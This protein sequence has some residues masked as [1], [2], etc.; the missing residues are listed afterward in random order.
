MSLAL[1]FHYWM[2]N[3]FRM[4][5]HPSSGACDLFVELFH[6]LYCSGSMCVG[7]TLWFGCGGVVSVCRLR[8]CFS[9]H[10][11]TTPPQPNH[12]VTPTHIDPE[13]Y[14]PWNNSTNKSQAPEDGCINI[15]N[16]LGIKSWNNK[17][18][19]IKL[20]SLYSTLRHVKVGTIICL[21]SSG[22][23]SGTK[24]RVYSRYFPGFPW[25]IP[26]A[27]FPLLL[28]IKHW[29]IRHCCLSYWQHC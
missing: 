3:M 4:L 5:I 28:F 2:L 23:T 6:G 14:N 8:H 7:V 21:V 13:Q 12:N 9:L 19:D 29:Q 15:Q 17:A 18:S 16:M 25:L 20:V 27:S 11:D 22:F 10:T 1:L 26:T 24:Y